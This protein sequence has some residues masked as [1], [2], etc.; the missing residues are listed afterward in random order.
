MNSLNIVV[1]SSKSMDFWKGRLNDIPALFQ[2][3][4]FETTMGILEEIEGNLCPNP[5][6]LVIVT[7]CV[8][9]DWRNGKMASFIETESKKSF[10][11]IF[12]VLPPELWTSTGLSYGFPVTTKTSRLVKTNHDLEVTDHF[13]TFERKPVGIPV[14]NKENIEQWLSLVGGKNGTC[15]GYA[16]GSQSDYADIEPERYVPKS[17][18]ERV[19]IFRAFCSRSAWYL[20]VI[21]SAVPLTFSTACRIQESEGKNYTA[22]IEVFLS[23]L[24]V[25]KEKE[26]E[27]EFLPGIREILGNGLP[28][29][30]ALRVLDTACQ[31]LTEKEGAFK[32]DQLL[33]VERNQTLLRSLALREFLSRASK[34][35]KRY[36]GSLS[37]QLQEID[38]IL[39]PRD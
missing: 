21:L 4:G 18:Q 9:D 15:K 17:P 31:H 27:F 23:G 8:S 39:S 6:H 32:L 34:T 29:D 35:V 14:I 24:L 38:L 16:F 37:E 1:E 25:R 28:R 30:V 5:S 13:W 11:T 33:K 22:L 12:Q 19:D 3:L 10:L 7:D 36:G 20:A 26:D 2:S